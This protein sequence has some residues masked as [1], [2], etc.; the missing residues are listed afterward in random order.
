MSPVQRR[1]FLVATGTLLAASLAH[2]QPTQKVRRIGYLSPE[3]AESEPG[4]RN[5][6][7]IRES[8]RRIGYEEGR[9]L[10]V[11]WRFAGAK[12]DRLDELAQDLVRRDVEL[13]VAFTNSP[14]LAAKRASR[15]VPIVMFIG[16]LPVELGIIE[17]LAHPG[18]QVT[19]TVWTSPET[20]GKIV[21]ILKEAAP[22]ATRVAALW[23]P[24]AVNK[25][26]LSEHRRAAQSLGMTYQYF[27]VARAE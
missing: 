22:G 21:Q 19:G 25:I 17:S 18:G 10:I 2:G 6:G 14:V 26:Y 27:D 15:T 9:N 12:P 7:L 13:I 3:V 4:R 5:Q 1:R 11:D 8:L 23:N 20:P 16:V 24:S